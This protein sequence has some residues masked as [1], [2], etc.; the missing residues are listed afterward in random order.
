MNSIK[1]LSISLMVAACTACFIFGIAGCEPD[2]GKDT[3]EHVHSFSEE[4]MSDTTEHWHEATCEHTDEKGS[5]G[6][7]ID[8][9]NNGKC[10]V[11]DYTMQT[12]EAHTHTFDRSHW[13]HDANTH[14]HAATCSDTT[15]R[16]DEAPHIDEDDNQAC[17]VC[18]EYVPH[19]HKFSETEWEFDLDNHWRPATCTDTNEKGSEAEHNFDNGGVCE[20]GLKE[21]EKQAYNSLIDYKILDGEENDFYTWLTGL[22]ADGK[23]VRVT[24]KSDIVYDH[25]GN[26]EVVYVAERTIKVKATIDGGNGLE[27]VWFKVANTSASETDEHNTNALG[28]GETGADGVATITF[29]PAGYTTYKI[30]LAEA[31]DVAALVG[32]EEADIKVMP[33]RY[34]V[35]NSSAGK[36][37]VGDIAVGETDETGTDD[38]TGTLDFKYD[39]SWAASDKQ[40]LPYERRYDD[41]V[42]GTGGP[43]EYGKEYNFT[44]TG[45]K[46]F[47]YLL[48]SPA[49]KYDW[50]AGST[51]ED[52]DKIT[53]NF[54]NAASGEYEISFTAE[55]DDSAR[56][57]YWGEIDDLSL[58]QKESDDSPSNSYV[59]SVSGTK[60]AGSTIADKAFTGENKVL[61]TIKPE[62]GLVD[63]QLGIICENACLVKITV[64]RLGDYVALE[65]GGV[66]T[67]GEN[68]N[69]GKGY[70]LNGSE[71]NN[72]V[73]A[74]TLQDVE[75]GL[76]YLTVGTGKTIGAYKAY[77]RSSE[78]TILYEDG[79]YKGVVRVNEGDTTLYLQYGLRGTGKRDSI[80]LEKYVAPTVGLETSW[81]PASG[82][83]CEDIEIGF[84]G[85]VSPGQYRM[86][87]STFGYE[88]GYSGGG[89]SDGFYAI[90]KVGSRSY[91]TSLRA[92]YFADQS[93]GALA[94]ECEY[95]PAVI[96]IKAGETLNLHV[97]T[98]QIQGFSAKVKL[99][100]Y[101]GVAVGDVITI[102]RPEKS[103]KVERYTFTASS[104]GTYKITLNLIEQ[105]FH[106]NTSKPEKF[107][108]G[109]LSTL[110]V[111][112]ETHNSMI[113]THTRAQ[114]YTGA[115]IEDPVRTLSGT[116]TMEEGGSIILAIS[117]TL[118]SELMKFSFTIE[119]VE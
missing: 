83:D 116:F 44:A 81:I 13:E 118:S 82:K 72:G 7:H 42:A 41:E 100:A 22:K 58:G 54:K 52:F 57:Y 80:S 63:F 30:M 75:P 59:T 89:T 106:G 107:T 98:P 11:C 73:T 103:S 8:E 27:H 38:I 85:A 112:D 109:D 50:N 56:L 14:W 96:E 69:G 87:I 16:Q 9:D 102:D 37:E 61:V 48:F 86:E 6:T 35:K 70:T 25:N 19:T 28:V 3:I 78:K 24:E 26:V 108:D 93:S 114:G 32:G 10:D 53:E 113:I 23:A 31:K 1:K 40:M 99:V 62:R 2:N 47:D 15:E 17:D 33:N 91:Q 115:P 71:D 84:D 104:A 101:G 39:V 64:K 51:S 110:D 45:G 68:T 21:V 94:N 60:P 5:V 95:N 97:T 67:V 77:C 105:Y 34:S 18:E 29:K 88:T 66:L 92:K 119:F 117:T 36:G 46:I 74:F 76:Y 20:C 55:G 4:W 43:K 65:T 79:K 111:K 12:G 49:H 90:V